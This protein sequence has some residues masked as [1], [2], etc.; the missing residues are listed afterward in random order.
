MCRWTEIGQIFSG[1]GKWPSRGNQ[2]PWEVR[3][4]YRGFEEFH[5]QPACQVG[6]RLQTQV[7]FDLGTW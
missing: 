5:F 1:P 6:I 4:C 7:A 3:S 2:V